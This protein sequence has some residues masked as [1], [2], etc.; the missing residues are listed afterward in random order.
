VRAEVRG[1]AELKLQDIE[2]RIGALVQLRDELAGLVEQCRA[3]A[4][5]CPIIE[6]MAGERA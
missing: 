3:S 6:H 2:A 4:G 5:C 1:L